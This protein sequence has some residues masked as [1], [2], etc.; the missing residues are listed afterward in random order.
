MKPQAIRG[1]V[2][3]T[4]PSGGFLWISGEDGID[5]FGHQSNVVN[6][7]Q[8]FRMWVGQS[9]TFIPRKGSRG[10]YAK[11]IEINIDGNQ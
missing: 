7:V 1:T 3:R 8:I 9:V 2:K 10:P 4:F 5:Y 6:G 11:F